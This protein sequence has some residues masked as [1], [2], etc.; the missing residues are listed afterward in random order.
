[1]SRRTRRHSR[2]KVKRNGPSSRR[3]SS[4]NLLWVSIIIIAVVLVGGGFAAIDRFKRLSAID[5]ET[6]CPDSGPSGALAVLLDLTDPLEE[7]QA[8]RL[9]T[10]L[11]SEFNAA[12][13]G[14][15][16]SVGIVSEDKARWGAAYSKCKPQAVEDANPLLQNPR[17]IGETY[18][19]E[20]IVPLD[21]TIDSLLHAEAEQ[22]SPIME[23][24]QAL[25]A[26]TP[27]L[28]TVEG[29][30][31]IVIVSDM[32]QNSSVLSFYR[33][34]FWDRFE[35]KNGTSRLAG[36]LKGTRIML[37]L[38]PRPS[39]GLDDNLEVDQFWIHY[40]DL[41]GAEPDFDIRPLGDL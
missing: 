18:N 38:V 12:D 27:A 19:D 41:Q 3:R 33:G 13:K 39:S 37:L 14:T 15:L 21:Q 9:R 26:A 7:T 40:F 30:R 25:I 5:V 16:I 36:S 23:S 8:I 22:T 17:M 35:Q 29:T 20:F 32:L 31:K 6:L 4:G 28:E 1:M 2:Q 10:I 34:E 11:G 24:L